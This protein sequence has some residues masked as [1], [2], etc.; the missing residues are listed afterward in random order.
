MKI[1]KHQKPAADNSLLKAGHGLLTVMD[2]N[3]PVVPMMLPTHILF[4]AVLA[5]PTVFVAPQFTEIALAAAV[6]GSI[7]P[8]LDLVANHRKTLHYPWYYSILAG[9]AV[10]VAY[11]AP[12]PSSVFAAFFLLAAAVH[13][14]VDIVGG[15]LGLRPWEKN[16]D[17][18]V[19]DHR[20]D[21]WIYPRRWIPYDGSP[22][23]FVL[24]VVL[25]LPLFYVY[26]DRIQ[27][28]LLAN[29]I[30]SLVYVLLRKKIVEWAPP[31]FK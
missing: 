7:L 6:M 4:G 21:K 1:F 9:I 30:V 11:L 16:D 15:D 18:G 31:R 24:L 10:V 3:Y 27:L 29:I 2:N 25:S 23:D 8:D 13:S 5:T 22:H 19:Y 28:L 26:D 17:R 12:E 14:V 20:R